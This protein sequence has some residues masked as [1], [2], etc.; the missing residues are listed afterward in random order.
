MAN[1]FSIRKDISALRNRIIVKS[2]RYSDNMHKFLNKQDNNNWKIMKNPVKSG[3]Y[4]ERYD[5]ET[6]SFE[7]INTKELRL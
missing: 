5:S 4:F 3:T 2:F 6:R 7:L 1:L